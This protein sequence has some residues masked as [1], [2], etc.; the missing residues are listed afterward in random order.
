MT[1]TQPARA[2]GAWL[3]EP[4]R[5]QHEKWPG[6]ASFVFGLGAVVYVVATGYAV[7][8][9]DPQLL[10]AVAVVP[11]LAFITL[12]VARALARLDNDPWVVPLLM[13]ALSAKLIGSG[14]RYWTAYSVYGGISDSSVYDVAGRAYASHWRHLDW[15]LFD[16]RGRLVGTNFVRI[17]TGIV[18]TVSPASRISGFLVS[19]WVGFFGLIL[20]W[21]AFRLAIPTGDVRKY[22][23]LVLFFP[24]L[25]YWPSSIGKEAWMILALGIV[26]YGAA[27]IA[28]GRTGG[29]LAWVLLG[30][31]GIIMI[32]PHIAICVFSGLTLLMI[33]VCTQWRRM[34]RPIVPMIAMLILFL[35]GNIVVQQTKRY[36]HVESLTQ[37]SVTATLNETTRRSSQGGSEF[38]PV[39]VNNPVKFPYGFATV[40]YR[41][42]PTEV[43]NTQQLI[44]SAE[45]LA[46]LLVTVLS[47]RSVVAVP[48]R[49]RSSPYVTY[50]LAYVVVFVVAFSA[51][52]NF[53]LLA[54]QRTQVLP[55][56]LVMLALPTGRDRAH[57]PENEEAALEEAPARP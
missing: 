8:S 38:A 30:T 4:P 54:R 15:G 10:G 25:L 40:F 53:G 35:A 46:L 23:V 55:L 32:R 41:P 42:F 5:P 22:A 21:R 36:L 1:V 6:W 44:A 20:F 28:V 14:V 33:I 26:A 16:M 12:L 24:S 27:S 49:I 2:R 31:A 13:A 29:G 45:G 7:Q 19:A 43:H 11:A 57:E 50:A 18:Y 52:S 48:R 17:L 47:W 39:R 34:R 56:Y 9:G 51:F 3:D 37:E